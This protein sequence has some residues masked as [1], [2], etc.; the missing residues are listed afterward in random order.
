MNGP[1][2]V[3]KYI[4]DT[5][6]HHQERS[7]PLGLETNRNHNTGSETYDGDED[8]DKR[9]FTLEYESKEQEDQ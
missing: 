6:H 8:A 7:G 9:P 3:S 1:P 2:V 4:E 5:Q